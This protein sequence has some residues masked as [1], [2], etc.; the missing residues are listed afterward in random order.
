M[1]DLKDG[2]CRC[3]ASEGTYKDFTASYQWM[4]AEE[5]Y[6]DMLKDCFDITLS[7][8]LVNNGGICE[9]CITQ[10]RNAF[11][12]KKQ[13]QNTEEQFKRMQDQFLKGD[14]VKIELNNDPM[15]NSDGGDNIDDDFS[16]PE[17]DVPIQSIKIEQMESK[18]K[19][20]PARA[21]TSKAK[22]PK[23]EVG[24]PSNK[25]FE[26]RS[27]NAVKCKNYRERKKAASLKI[28]KTTLTSAERSRMYRLRKKQL[29][30]GT[31]SS[32]NDVLCTDNDTAS[33]LNSQIT[34][35]SSPQPVNTG[36]VSKY[37][38]TSLM[39]NSRSNIFEPI[40]NIKIEEEN[41]LSDSEDY[42]LKY[43]VMTNNEV[44]K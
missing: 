17:Y 28:K 20:R 34:F 6:G 44:R 4:G 7:T 1:E 36:D 18:T 35:E 21:S 39:E 30:Q 19:K 42:E 3:C 22:K 33:T 38:K 40:V 27:K 11:N 29:A 16:S 8:S 24:E 12:F 10:L 37:P 13:V 14:I 25:L 31:K 15:E 41:S 5:V 26:M 23:V 43:S 32:V 2:M 9:V